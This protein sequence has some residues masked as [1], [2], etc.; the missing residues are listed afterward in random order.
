MLTELNPP[1]VFTPSALRVTTD[2]MQKL[3]ALTT[4]EEGLPLLKGSFKNSTGGFLLKVTNAGSVFIS[5]CDPPIDSDQ[6]GGAWGQCES[7]ISDTFLYAVDLAECAHRSDWN[8]SDLPP[9]RS[10]GFKEFINDATSVCEQTP[11]PINLGRWVQMVVALRFSRWSCLNTIAGDYH[12]NPD[13]FAFASKVLAMKPDA[14]CPPRFHFNAQ[15]K[16]MVLAAKIMGVM[17]CGEMRI[18]I[19]FAQCY[20]D[21]AYQSVFSEGATYA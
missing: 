5:D 12:L 20:A 2:F 21:S 3:D 1:R 14:V 16:G 13:A 9:C 18:H 15:G 6:T 10:S 8:F 11:P 19:P 4:P 7:N 17:G